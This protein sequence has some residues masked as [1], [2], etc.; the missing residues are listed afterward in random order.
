MDSQT[1]KVETEKI[2]SRLPKEAT[3]EDL[4]YAIYV[5]QTV[6]KGLADIEAGRTQDVHEVRKEFGLE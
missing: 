4:M 5:R 3:W 2:I 6:E 1:L